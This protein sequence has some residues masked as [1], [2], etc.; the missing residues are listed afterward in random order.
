MAIA[1]R[2][3]GGTRYSTVYG[4]KSPGFGYTCQIDIRECS[5]ANAGN[6]IC[7][8]VEMVESSWELE[9]MSFEMIRRSNFLKIAHVQ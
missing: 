2:M 9:S 3:D 6:V 5:Y 4:R 8:N 1:A 7:V